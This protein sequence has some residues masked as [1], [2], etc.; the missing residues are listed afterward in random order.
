MG[1]ALRVS[2]AKIVIFEELFSTSCGGGGG[3]HAAML[4]AAMLLDNAGSQF[5]EDV[6]YALLRALDREGAPVIR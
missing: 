6:V 5:S 4:N 2:P 1:A 3:P